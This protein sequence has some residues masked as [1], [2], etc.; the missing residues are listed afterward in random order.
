MTNNPIIRHL[1]P[2]GGVEASRVHFC[3]AVF[4]YG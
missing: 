4:V 1:L 3:D 2:Q